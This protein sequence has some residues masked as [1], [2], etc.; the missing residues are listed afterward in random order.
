VRKEANTRSAVIRTLSFDV[1]KL[2]Q[3]KATNSAIRR[4]WV[5]VVLAD[6]QKGY[7]AA[8]YIRSPIDYRAIFV[9]K[10][11]KW[12]MTAFIAGD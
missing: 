4:Q 1:V 3:D 8:D 2:G 5:P 9:K 6:G 10:G 12:I 7:V 11:G